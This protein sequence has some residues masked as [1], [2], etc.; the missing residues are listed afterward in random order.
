VGEAGSRR[1]ARI[2]LPTAPLAEGRFKRGHP[3]ILLRSSPPP[4][5]TRAPCCAG[6]R[7][8]TGEFRTAPAV[9]AAGRASRPSIRS[10][11]LRLVQRATGSFRRGGAANRRAR[12]RSP[13]AQ[14]ARSRLSEQPC[15]RADATGWKSAALVLLTQTQPPRAFAE[16][17]L[18]LAAL[19]DFGPPPRRGKP[20]A[21]APGLLGRVGPA[22]RPLDVGCRISP[23]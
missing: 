13:H 7:R 14:P 11:A 16:I 3:L 10:A 21:T 20:T 12:R 9:A 17:I 5:R 6:C 1:R 15:R 22:E 23:P 2:A 4:R 8:I 18:S 19:L